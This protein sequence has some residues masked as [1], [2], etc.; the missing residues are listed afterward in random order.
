MEITQEMIAYCNETFPTQ[1][2]TEPAW[3]TP[4][5]VETIWETEWGKLSRKYEYLNPAD[6]D[7]NGLISNETWKW[8]NG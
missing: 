1:E 8:I 2:I 3:A 5:V 4:R 6:S 7:E